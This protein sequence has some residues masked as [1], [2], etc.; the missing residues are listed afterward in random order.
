V[1]A[2]NGKI[3]WQSR[4]SELYKGNNGNW[5][6][7]E[8][9]IVDSLHVYYTPGG[10]ET[11][12]VALNKQTGA[13]V[14]KSRSLSDKA[15]YVSPILVNYAGKRMLINATLRHLYGVDV[16]N[17]KILW[18][19]AFPS[20][21]KW[22]DHIVCVTPLFKDGM[23]YITE[24][25]NA[26]GMMVRLNQNGTDAKIAWTE[27]T[28]DTHTGG[29]VEIDG[30]IYGS[31][32]ISNRDGNWCCVDWNTGKLLYEES[33]QS[34]GSIIAADGMLYLYAEKSGIMAL[35]K[36]NPYRLEVVSSF[37]ITEGTGPHWAH[38]VIHNGYLFVRHGKAL[39]VYNITGS[40]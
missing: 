18:S 34:K 16:E 7:A 2:L 36:P 6:I 20:E 3:I 33:W 26:G 35:A 23:V 40:L 4:A 28:M 21:A 19:V 14:W 13:L 11:T 5:G 25:Y 15:S 8:S 17:G 10:N 38:P 39:L 1:D 12:T 29:V 24:G 22:G 30:K 27:K 32:W 9:L 31:G 37:S